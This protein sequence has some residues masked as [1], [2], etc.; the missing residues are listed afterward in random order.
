MLTAPDG[1]ATE[2]VRGTSPVNPPLGVTVIGT[3]MDP[4]R[5]VMVN[6]LPDKLKDFVVDDPIT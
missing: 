6:V 4:P 2:Q 5:Q 3:W 1:A